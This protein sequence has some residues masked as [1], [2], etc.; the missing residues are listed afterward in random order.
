MGASAKRILANVNLDGYII[1][2][3]IKHFRRDFFSYIF[4]K[5]LAGRLELEPWSVKPS[6]ADLASF[7]ISYQRVSSTLVFS[8]SDKS[9]TKTILLSVTLLFN[10]LSVFFAYYESDT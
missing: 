2:S 3:K 5:K 10:I 1:T 6:L 9:D 4:R 8:K 7:R